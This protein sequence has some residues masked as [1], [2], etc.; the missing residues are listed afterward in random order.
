MMVCHQ[1]GGNRTFEHMKEGGL[2]QA[3]E[4]GLF[5]EG[6]GFRLMA[7]GAISVLLS[8]ICYSASRG[9]VT[10]TLLLDLQV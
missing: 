6:C 2:G 3:S 10:I 1:S 7:I 4:L 9:L 8:Q 5:S